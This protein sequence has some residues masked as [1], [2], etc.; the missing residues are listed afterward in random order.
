MHQITHTK[1]TQAIINRMKQLMGTDKPQPTAT[2]HI[3]V[4]GIEMT[5]PARCR[6]RDNDGN[7]RTTPRLITGYNPN[8]VTPFIDEHNLTWS[9]AMPVHRCVNQLVSIREECLV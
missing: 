4:D 7:Y 8:S 2:M 5:L 3:I 1:P 6:V 9:K